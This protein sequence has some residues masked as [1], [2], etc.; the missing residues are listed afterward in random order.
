MITWKFMRTL[1]NLSTSQR[2]LLRLAPA[3]PFE[4]PLGGFVLTV[5]AIFIAGHLLR[6]DAL[7]RLAYIAA[8]GLLAAVLLSG[9]I[10]GAIVTV[11][12]SGFITRT[13]QYQLY[14]LLCLLPGGTVRT[15]W[16]LCVIY[17]HHTRTFQN[18]G[19]QSAWITRFLFS[20]VLVFSNS[21]PNPNAWEGPL[22]ALMQIL[23]LYV[24]F[25][26]DDAQSLVLACLIAM[27]SSIHNRTVIDARTFSLIAYL[28]VQFMTYATTFFVAFTFLHTL[29][30]SLNITGIAAAISQLFVTLGV[31]F[32]FREVVL[33]FLSHKLLHDLDVPTADWPPFM[34]AD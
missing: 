3:Q 10:Q 28:F 11:R 14:D 5:I 6:S 34:L 32:A 23:I 16:S 29:Y 20:Q 18:I 27:V 31:F 4:L 15:N 33:R 9:L 1:R 26:I 25:H 21:R 8:G 12:L 2:P 13:R 7:T 19:S 17:L 22:F 30:I 24:A